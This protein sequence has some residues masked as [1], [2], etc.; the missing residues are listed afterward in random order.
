MQVKTLG[1]RER[2][3]RCVDHVPRLSWSVAP[4]PA[5]T[6]PMEA[7]H[8]TKKQWHTN[9]NEL[10]QTCNQS[11]RVTL[12]W[13]KKLGDRSY[14]H[15]TFQHNMQNASW[16]AAIIIHRAPGVRQNQ[17]QQKPTRCP[18]DRSHFEERK[19]VQGLG[20]AAS[21]NLR[22]DKKTREMFIELDL[23]DI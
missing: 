2:T 15:E 16:H 20:P 9:S 3:F 12:K 4:C 10:Q 18:F 8:E 22:T 11:P 23:R 5:T 1:C 13:G 21:P 19:E 6:H 17:G 7:H 14:W